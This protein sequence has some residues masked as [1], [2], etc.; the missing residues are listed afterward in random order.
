MVEE[1]PKDAV[2]GNEFNVNVL[3]F[4][5]DLDE[6]D[7]L[8]LEGCKLVSIDSDELTIVNNQIHIVQTVARCD[9]PAEIQCRNNIFFKNIGK[10]DYIQVA[11]DKNCKNTIVIHKYDCKTDECQNQIINVKNHNLTTDCEVFV[12]GDRCYEYD[13]A[14]GD[15]IDVSVRGTNCYEK[16]NTPEDA[17][18]WTYEVEP[19]DGVEC[20]DHEKNGCRTLSVLSN[21]S[22][23]FYLRF[24]WDGKRIG[25]CFIRMKPRVERLD[26]ELAPIE[27]KLPV[28]IRRFDNGMIEVECFR[29][30]EIEVVAKAVADG[31]RYSDDI[32]NPGFILKHNGNSEVS[33]SD[34]QFKQ[35]LHFRKA[36]KKSLKFQSCDKVA[37]KAT[38]INVN[39]K[40]NK[41]D[42]MLVSMISGIVLAWFFFFLNYG[43]GFWT[44]LA[45]LIPAGVM[46]WYRRMRYPQYT[47]TMFCLVGADL[48][49]FLWSVIQE[50]S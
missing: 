18:S 13:M 1:V 50:I 31:C 10:C 30:Q 46:Y 33:C 28:E 15:T 11:M 20:K 26:C 4:G 45:Y 48:I 7:T 6:N 32:Y 35:V 49:M 22:G 25:S 17:N 42:V 16:A 23:V 40:E 9:Q 14:V 43:I 41:S 27:I 37:N 8:A 34:G 36:G 39:V 2:I 21:A 24:L 38:I 44:F 47:K 12:N 3:S 19:S 29:D 5:C